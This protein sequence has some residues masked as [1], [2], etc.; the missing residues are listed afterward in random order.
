MT[1]RRRVR[2]PYTT[3]IV[4]VAEQIGS[5]FLNR[6]TQVRLL[7]GTLTQMPRDAP[8]VATPLSTG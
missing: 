3:Q 7:P 8:L 2:S 5:G 6:P 1:Q 4:L